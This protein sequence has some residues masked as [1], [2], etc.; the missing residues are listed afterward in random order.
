MSHDPSTPRRVLDEDDL[1]RLGAAVAGV[2]Q[3]ESD[4]VAVYLYGS[5]ARGEA[6]R[7]VDLGL[8]ASG[9]VTPTRLRTFVEALYDRGAAPGPLDLDVR[10]LVGT[11]PRFRATVVREGRVIFER[12]PEARLAFE[13]RSLLDW[14]DFE[15]VW[16][17][18]RARMLARWT[19][20]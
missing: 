18:M 19:D 9:A 14:L 2:F 8:L 4:I 3:G 20:G 11:A 6:A 5:A 10:P 7:D 13:K 12:D 16:R 15:P 17:K 1:R